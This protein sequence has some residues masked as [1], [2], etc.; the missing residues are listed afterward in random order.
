MR[1]SQSPRRSRSA[2]CATSPAACCAPSVVYVDTSAL[3]ALLI[4]QPES[5][6][7]LD[8]LDET[9]ATLVSSDLAETELRRIAVRESLDQSDVT[10]L[11]DGVARA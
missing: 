8:W 9:N 11:L 6:A 2:S 7:L 4:E 1:R 3:C 10:R 5:P